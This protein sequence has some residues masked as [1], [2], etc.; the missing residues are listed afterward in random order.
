MLWGLQ[1]FSAVVG[2][3]FL[4]LEAPKFV[5]FGAPVSILQLL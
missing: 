4:N 2:S 5:C 1:R 3:L